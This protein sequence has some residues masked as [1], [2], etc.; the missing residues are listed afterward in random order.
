VL[1][2]TSDSYY[3]GFAIFV[4]LC[5]IAAYGVLGKPNHELAFA[6]S[7]LLGALFLLVAGVWVLAAIQVAFSAMAFRKWW[8][9][10]RGD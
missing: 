8:K 3:T 7:W 5:M 1:P 9:K 4:V 2:E 6:I 10:Y